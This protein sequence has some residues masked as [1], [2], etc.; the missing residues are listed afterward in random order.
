MS[1]RLVRVAA[2]AEQNDAVH[3]A[4][5]LLLLRNRADRGN[6]TIDGITKLAKMDFLVRYPIYFQRLLNQTRQRPM[7]VPMQ[8]FESD[9]VESRMVRF[10]YGPWD[11]RYRRWIGLLVAKGLATTYLAG[12]TVHVKIT[13]KGRAYAEMLASTD[14]FRD[15][16]ERSRLVIV[17]VGGMAGSRLKELVYE[18]VPELTSMSWGQEIGL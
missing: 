2:R 16:D 5:L 3:E 12:K 15:L 4:R 1:I 17:A 6:G 14:E 8:D 13:D 9:T 11:P 7:Q 18:V 10:R